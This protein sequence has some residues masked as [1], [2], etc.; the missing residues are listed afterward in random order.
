MIQ[1][2]Y[3][4]KFKVHKVYFS[5]LQIV[6]LKKT[7]ENLSKINF[8]QPQALMTNEMVSM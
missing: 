1:N 8:N 6:I 7:L 4:N 5:L 2:Q 3:K